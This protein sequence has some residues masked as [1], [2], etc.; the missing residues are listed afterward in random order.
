M[1]DMSKYL[2]GNI[3][4][5]CAVLMWG[6]L[7][8]LGK[9]SQTLDTELVMSI[10]FGIAGLIGVFFCK[11]TGRQFG[12][13]SLPTMI[14][15]ASLLTGYHLAYLGSFKLAPALN[16]SLINYLWPA[17]FIVI[18]NTFFGLGSGLQGFIGAL[19]GFLSIPILMSGDSA[20]SYSGSAL[21]GCA[22]AF[23]GALIWAIYSNL[24]RHDKADPICSMTLICL[25]SSVVCI[26]L[27]MFKNSVHIELTSANL[28]IVLLLAIG[29]AGGAFFLWDIGM[30]LG[31][32]ALLAVFGYC[33]PI[34]STILLIL[35][36]L[37]EPSWNVLVSVLLIAAGGAVVSMKT[38]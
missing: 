10:C 20:I 1:N 24:R 32:P 9:H 7:G 16:V 23:I 3:C 35:F 27:L 34:I 31:N 11:L 38:K 17:F 14:F 37:A 12:K 25:M 29:P 22:L 6:T 4:G 2:I 5:V 36:G 15:Y 28:L 26:T 30:R 19:L 18:G 21:L 8:V 33:A 13:N